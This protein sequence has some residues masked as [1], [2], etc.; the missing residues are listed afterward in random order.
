MVHSEHKTFTFLMCARLLKSKGIIEYADAVLLLRQKNLHFRCLLLGAEEKH[1]DA[2]SFAQI[3]TWQQERGLFYLGFTDDVRPHLVKADCFVYPSY[4]NEGIPRSLMEACSMELPV[5]TTDN[6]GCRNLIQDGI[7]G[8]LC[9]KRDPV[10][11]ADKMENMMKFDTHHRAQMGRKGMEIVKANYSIE[12]VVIFYT[13]I[14]E[15]FFG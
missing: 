11:L 9:N 6:T 15:S 2:I 7:N 8:F 10:S 14:L 4:Y 1:P 3:F 13:R 12:K 5:I